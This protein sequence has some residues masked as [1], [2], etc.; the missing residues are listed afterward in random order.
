MNRAWRETL[1]YA[2]EEVGTLSVF[3]VIHPDCQEHGRDLFQRMI[4]GEKL[5]GIEVEFLTR[6]GE[7]VIVE[8]N[9]DCRVAGGKVESTRGIFRNIT[10]RKLA[11]AQLQQA[12]E[13]AEAANRAKSEF[14]ANMS[15]EIRTPMNGVLGMTE[16]LLD[17]EL[18]A[19]Q[20]EYMG[21][22]KTSAES[23]LGVINDILDFSKIEAASWNWSPSIS[24]CVAPSN[25]F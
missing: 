21:L 10:K 8:G 18:D 19:E 9:A 15:H 7:K 16:L 6:N 14:V 5:D 25:P 3:Q 4:S 23:L 13:V 22:V 1:G 12:K 17:T 24:D 20:R 11:D 2:E